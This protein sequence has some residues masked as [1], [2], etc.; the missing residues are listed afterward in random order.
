M[1][2]LA[3]DARILVVRLGALRDVVFVGPAVRALRRRYPAARMTAWVSPAGEA[4]A[5][6]LPG[7]NDVFVGATCDTDEGITGA[8]RGGAL[9]M[10]LAMRQ[11]AAAFLF[12]N[13]GETPYA[14][15]FVAAAAGIP[16]RVGQSQEWGGGLLT[17]WVKPSRDD[18]HPVDRHLHLLETVGVPAAG[19]DLRLAVPDS[20]RWRVRSRLR[21]AGIRG[22]FVVVAP[23]GTCAARRYEAHHYV[24]VL[25][26]LTTRGLSVILVGGLHD[27]AL[28]AALAT[29]VPGVLSWCGDLVFPELAALLGQAALFLGHAAGLMYVAHALARPMVILHA[30]TEPLPSWLSDAPQITSLQRAVACSP[31]YQLTC[32][33]DH[34][35]LDVDPHDV[36]DAVVRRLRPV[37]PAGMPAGTPCRITPLR[38]SE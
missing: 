32:P 15:A 18:G 12:T 20:A 22:R 13:A 29:A 9:P 11:F 5:R 10:S 14:A 21:E 35:C 4:V 6:C 24:A 19:R 7:V 37:H 16:V 25:G 17:D 33:H 27:R 26:E 28:G 1:E 23:G 31:C 38:L 3:A 30:G 34:Q 8:S 2:A 36:A